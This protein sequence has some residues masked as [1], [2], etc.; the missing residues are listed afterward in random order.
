[1]KK[2]KLKWS[3]MNKKQRVLFVID[4][5]MRGLLILLA[6]IFIASFVFSCFGTA[7]EASAYADNGSSDTQSTSTTDNSAADQAYI[8]SGFDQYNLNLL[9][10]SDYSVAWNG[11]TLNINNGTLT[12]NGMVLNSSIITFDNVGTLYSNINYTF[13]LYSNSSSLGSGVCLY[14][15][16]DISIIY[17]YISSLA[18]GVYNFT[19]DNTVQY[20]FGMFVTGG[21]IF[22]NVVLK[23]MLVSGTYTAETMP[24][25]Q[26]NLKYI[27]EQA[28]NTGNSA[29]Y[30]QGENDG[31]LNGYNSANSFIPLYD[32]SSC[33]LNL[34]N[35]TT[36]QSSSD[37]YTFVNTSYVSGSLDN[38][39]SFRLTFPS[40]LPPDI[41]FTIR[42]LNP[43]AYYNNGSTNIEINPNLNL[44]F[45]NDGNFLGNVNFVDME[46]TVVDG[47]TYYSV[48]RLFS[49]SITSVVLKQQSN[50][51]SF[52]DFQIG[53]KGETTY[54]AGY[55]TGFDKGQSQGYTNGYNVGKSEGYQLGFE[56]A[57]AG[58]F[59]WLISSVQSFLD[60]KFFGDFGIGT[61]LYVGLG[62]MLCTLFI[63]F[64]AGG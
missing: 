2:T 36:Q 64:F 23:P 53:Y 61:L 24:A 14:G 39:I 1:M 3:E 59:S 22:N 25:Y 11:L 58:G 5:V 48:N 32:F 63:K 15:I 41:M 37:P 7:S 60:T 54:D 17:A 27:Y 29:G 10:L 42:W 38:Q 30:E 45:Y 34:L 6:V 57:G 50:T 52:T 55:Q 4:W 31:Y 49:S 16:D 12:I 46:K 28:Y 35:S 8:N 56:A 47:V 33:E 20:R 43:S 18:S 21:Q 62:I 40:F 26:P 19:V 13:G 9:N 44:S 51:F